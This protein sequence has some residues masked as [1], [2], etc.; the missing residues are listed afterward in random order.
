M[1]TLLMDETLDEA[2]LQ[3]ATPREL[4]ALASERGWRSLAEDGLDRVRGGDTSLAEI[5]RVVDLTRR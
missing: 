5:R 3:G 4:A 1:E 2:V